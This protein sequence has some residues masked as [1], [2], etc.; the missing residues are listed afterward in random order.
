MNY[1]EIPNS[2]DEIST[3]LEDI[4]GIEVEKIDSNVT[5]IRMPLNPENIDVRTDN[6]VIKLISDRIDE[7]EIDLSPDFQR[8]QG[9]WSIGDKSRLIESLLLRIP[10]PVFY[11]STDAHDMWAVVDGVQRFSTISDFINNKFKLMHLEYLTQFDGLEFQS[12]PRSFQRRILETQLV[13]HVIKHGTPNEVKFNIFHRINTGGKPLNRQEIRHAL[14]PGPIREFLKKLANSP[15][16]LTATDYSIGIKRMSDRECVLRYLA[17]YLQDWKN[18]GKSENIDGFLRKAMERIN[19]INENERTELAANFVRTMRAANNIFGSRAF[20]KPSPQPAKRL[21][22][23]VSLF[24]SWSVALAHCTDEQ[25][26]RL[27]RSKKRL[28]SEFEVIVDEDEEF[29]W[30]I[31]YSTGNSNRVHK[32]FETVEELVDRFCQC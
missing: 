14:Y 26:T 22:I 12:L 6:T 16:F 30:S 8:L 7:G 11:V 17:F 3:E 5:D 31:S 10:I 4:D 29:L 2:A 24:E 18:Y 27:I 25:L 32:R 9:I 20:R 15:E 19:A 28:I 13:V 1:K 23:N 21:P